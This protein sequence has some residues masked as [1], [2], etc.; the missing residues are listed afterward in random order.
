M[1]SIRLLPLVLIAVSCLL[2]L[3]TAGL[4]LNSSFLI[5]GVAPAHA[6]SPS[7]N[8]QTPG[9]AQSPAPTAEQGQ[10]GQGAEQ[11]AQ[12]EQ[13]ADQDPPLQPHP[14]D[15]GKLVQ[16]GQDP[17]DSRSAVLE[18]LRERR[19]QLEAFE[20]EVTMRENL[21]QAAEKQ[22]DTRIAELKEIEGRISAAVGEREE[23]Q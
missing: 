22:L 5:G 4:L 21:L 8:E 17:D 23:E 16:P 10:P 9:T 19:Q 20:R 15:V 6:Q 1:T 13:T 2:V 3:K 12:G 11:A 18:R 14:D 7:G